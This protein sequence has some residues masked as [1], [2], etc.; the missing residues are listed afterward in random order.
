METKVCHKCHR[1]LPINKF[2][3]D[4]TTNDGYS[5]KCKE[6]AAKYHKDWVN[7]KIAKA[8]KKANPLEYYSAE[9]MIKELKGRMS[10]ITLIKK[11]MFN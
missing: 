8:V 6:C 11:L 9:E 1:E 3:K 7:R 5:N 4:V 10:T 2:S